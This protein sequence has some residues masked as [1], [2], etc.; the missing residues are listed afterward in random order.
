MAMKSK[1]QAVK[2]Q[3]CSECAPRKLIAAEMTYRRRAAFDEPGKCAFCG[4]EGVLKCYEI[5]IGR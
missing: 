4:H 2:R 1:R 5:M 3:L